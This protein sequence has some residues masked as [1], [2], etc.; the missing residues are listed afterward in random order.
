MTKVNLNTIDKVKNFVAIT[1]TFSVDV[2]MKAGKYVVDGKSIMGLFSLNLDEP[3]T[4]VIDTD[5]DAIK[6]ECMTAL[7][8]FI[9]KE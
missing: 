2:T 8:E 4:I 5:N 9:V 7:E 1:N 3:I 6:T